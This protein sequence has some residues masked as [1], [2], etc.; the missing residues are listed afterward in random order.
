MEEQPPDINTAPKGHLTL[1][2]G[3]GEKIAGKIID[4]RS[5]KPFKDVNDVITRVVGIGPKKGRFV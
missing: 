4:E 3:I 5:K 1:V 2:D